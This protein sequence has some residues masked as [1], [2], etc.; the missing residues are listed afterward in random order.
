MAVEQRVRLD[1]VVRLF[2]TSVGVVNR[3]DTNLLRLADL[4]ACADA[5]FEVE[6]RTKFLIACGGAGEHRH[7]DARFN[8]W[9]YVAAAEFVNEDRGEGQRMRTTRSIACLPV[10]VRG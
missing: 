8:E 7:A 6:R 10:G 2:D 1:T 3:S 4:K 5:V 9:L